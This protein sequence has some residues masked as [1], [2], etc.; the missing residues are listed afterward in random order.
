MN[1]FIEYFYGIKVDKINYNEK[2]YSFFNNG[3]LYKM[4]IINDD[5][6]EINS[7]I[8][9]NKKLI[10]STLVSEIV[11]N[12]NNEAVSIYNGNGFILIKIYVNTNKKISL[13]EIVTLNNSMY[14]E[15]LNINWGILWEK[16]IDYLEDLIN[17]NGKK[18]PLIVDSF[19]YFVGLAE[20]AISYYY[21]IKIEPNYKYVLS[22]K[23]IKMNDTIEAL[24]NPLNIIF[25]YKTR[26]ISE[27]IK[28]S[29]FNENKK[30]FEELMFYLQNNNLLLTD[31][32][33][34]I[35]RVLYPSFYFDLYEDIMIYNKKENIITP[36]INKIDDYEEYLYKIISFFKKYYDIDEIEWLKKRK[37]YNWGDLHSHNYSIL[38]FVNY[39]YYF[40]YFIYQSRFNAAF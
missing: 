11:I 30:I 2:Y 38:F 26:D 21:D 28:I 18:Y 34:L 9:I 32:K 12:R 36:I 23:T 1:N 4:Y 31:I 25:D 24:Y 37:Y 13:M 29:F 19:N 39:F 33:L 16:K 5:G 6:K 40:W 15:K 10:K 7:L 17:E 14:L 35:A 20:N 27:Y 3:Y 22:H 8:N